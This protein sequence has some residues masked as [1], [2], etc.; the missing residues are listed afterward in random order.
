MIG[1]VSKLLA[2][3]LVFALMLAHGSAQGGERLPAPIENWLVQAAARGALPLEA[4]V[5]GSIA[6][7]P[8]SAAAIVAR[9]AALAPD[10]SDR[11]VRAAA[12][13]FPAF[14]DRIT[15]GIGGVQPIVPVAGAVPAE[16][17]PEAEA[18]REWSGEIEVGASAS[19]GNTDR[20][21]ANIDVMV[22]DERLLWRHEFDFRLDFA[23]DQDETTEQ[24]VIT[25][26]ETNYKVM[27]R[28]YL[29]GFLLYEDDRFSGFDYRITESV[30]L[31]YRV[32]DLAA[33]R[34]NLEAGVGFRQSRED[35]SDAFDNEV[36]G[37]FDGEFAWDVS[38]SAKFTEETSIF[39]GV[40]RTT[41]DST[42]ALT[43]EIL[44]PFSGRLS[45]N[46]RH[47]TDAPTGTEPTD[48]LTKASLVYRF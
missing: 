4:A 48:T 25:S 42:T 39:V 27:G 46:L 17:R 14:K 22:V 28:A 2:G 21:T 44:D 26:L 1:M 23:E 24:R 41:I 31:G 15:A 37:R 33:L 20:T 36:I 43:M 45:F 10:L 3:F 19:S 47:D 18:I 13:A 7:E 38:K 11:M 5:I 16:A 34:L 9:A 29:L 40:E 35:V 30:G 12:E 32:V 6:S 8:A